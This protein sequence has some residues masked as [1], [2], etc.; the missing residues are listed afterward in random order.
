MHDYNRRVHLGVTID[1][2]SLTLD[3]DPARMHQVLAN[4][5][6]NAVRHSPEGGCVNL[7]ARRN[8]NGV[9]LEVSDQGPGIP[10][11]DAERVFERF[12]RSDHARSGGDGGSGLG[13][14]IARWIVELHDGAIRA[15]TGS[16]TGCRMVV[17]LPSR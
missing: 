5:V 2:P 9:V 6:A 4:L 16:P 15:E 14:A 11:G 13:L 17:E 1:P 12:Y 7:V 3:A 10:P 8:G